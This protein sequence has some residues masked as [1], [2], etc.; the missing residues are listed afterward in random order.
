[1]KELIFASHN[2]GKVAEIKAMLA[3]LGINVLSSSEV[4]AP[5]VE[6]TGVTFVENA[7]LKAETICE[8]L[9][10]PCLA[11]DSGLCVDALDGKPGVFTKRWSEELGHENIYDRILEELALVSS[12]ERGAEFICVLA[13]SR[14]KMPTETFQGVSRGTIN[15]KPLGDNGFGQDPIFIPEGQNRTYGQMSPEEKAKT[16]H[17]NRAL[18]AFLKYLQQ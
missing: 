8:L 7:V 16:S 4:N 3:P 2:K 14:P 1:M 5:D 18:N 17:R 13:L 15:D 10:T 6:E 11:D 9:Q 12:N